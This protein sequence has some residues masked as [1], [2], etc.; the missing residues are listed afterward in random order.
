MANVLLLGCKPLEVTGFTANVGGQ[1]LDVEDAAAA[2]LRY[3]NGALG[4]ITS[5]YYNDG[6]PKHSHIKVWGS[7]GW[8][9]LNFEPIA[10]EG[11]ERAPLRCVAMSDLG[12]TRVNTPI[13]LRVF[14]CYYV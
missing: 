2:A 4:T 11:L 7:K 5:G 1:P 8:L 13:N 14:P 9:E 3:E 6:G 10:N 12:G